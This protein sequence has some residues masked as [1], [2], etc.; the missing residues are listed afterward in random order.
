MAATMM[1]RD[2]MI[3]ETSFITKLHNGPDPLL[4]LKNEAIDRLGCVAD[5][6]PKY[7]KNIDNLITE[8]SIDDMLTLMHTIY[9]DTDFKSSLYY[10]RYN[11]YFDEI[12]EL[13][14]KYFCVE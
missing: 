12:E 11:E 6:L 4:L 8:F 7:K 1:Q 9:R 13:I 3:A 10:G 2:T 14:Y 5:D